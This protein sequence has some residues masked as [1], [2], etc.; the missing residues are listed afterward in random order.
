MFFGGFG[1]QT[2]CEYIAKNG[3]NKL[4]LNEIPYSMSQLDLGPGEALLLP[5]I[6][7]CSLLPRRAVDKEMRLKEILGHSVCPPV[8]EV[9]R[10]VLLADF[11]TVSSDFP[12]ASDDS[13]ELI[14]P[15]TSVAD[16]INQIIELI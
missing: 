6:L 13:A 1:D 8:E 16:F 4:A 5:N 15:L 10:P 9:Y 2:Y 14:I 12:L 3:T 7:K 11:I